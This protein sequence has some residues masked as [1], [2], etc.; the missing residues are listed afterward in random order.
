M[1]DITVVVTWTYTPA[2]YFEEPIRIQELGYT[3][4]IAAGNVEARVNAAVYD[5]DT[6]ATKEK[7]CRAV[8]AR[9]LKR[10]LAAYTTY[11]LTGPRLESR[12]RDD[13]S[14][15]A[16]T[17]FVQPLPAR[18]VE[19]ATVVDVV[20]KDSAGN[21]VKDTARERDKRYSELAELLA[22]HSELDET[23]KSLLASWRSAIADQAS[24]L[25]HLYEIRDA[26]KAVRTDLNISA[27]DWSRLG[28]LANDEPLRQGRHGGSKKAAHELR[29]ATEAE[30]KEA[31][32][33]ALCM[34]EAYLR[35]LERP[36]A[37]VPGAQ[38]ANE[39]RRHPSDD[40]KPVPGKPDKQGQ[41]RQWR[42]ENHPVARFLIKAAA[43]VVGIGAVVGAL[44]VIWDFVPSAARPPKMMIECQGGPLPKTT[45]EEGRIYLLSP[46]PIAAEDGGGGLQEVF[47]QPGSDWLP[48]DAPRTGYGCRFVN[49]GEDPAFRIESVFGV[50]FR[51]TIRDA[52]N[53]E[54]MQSGAVVLSRGWQVNLAKVEAGADRPFV[55]YVM[56]QSDHFMDVSLPDKATLQL[57]ADEAIQTVPLIRSTDKALTLPPPD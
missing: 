44:Q 4:V 42:L 23:A 45:P 5:A 6:K 38:R 54:S 7:I 25:V 47:G 36:P 56:N 18:K 17:V 48:A 31:R 50:A 41:P 57:E 26:L 37:P 32:D 53:P 22:K 11:E 51:E 49:Y 29:D 14:N 39:P 35:Y 1:A 2:D 13:G 19:F 21:V 40:L 28:Q 12:V 20:T 10:Q 24:E 33:I 8:D 15:S 55:F 27:K 30:L 46:F 16:V 34:I 43:V 52:Q 3:I 9:F